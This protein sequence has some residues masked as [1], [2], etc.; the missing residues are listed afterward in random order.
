MK[1]NK[2]N[3]LPEDVFS[4]TM[5]TAEDPIE[6]LSAMNKGEISRF[7]CWKILSLIHAGE[8]SCGLPQYGILT[9]YSLSK[10]FKQFTE[11]FEQGCDMLRA[12]GAISQESEEAAFKKL[13]AILNKKIVDK[14]N[15][16]GIPLIKKK[17]SKKNNKSKN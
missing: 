12:E 17:K 8:I 9:V 6:L 15:P 4:G 7:S 16:I 2:N 11:L 5:L 14:S 3:E 10:D 13:S 1:N